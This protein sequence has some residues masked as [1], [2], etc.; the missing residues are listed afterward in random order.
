[1]NCNTGLIE[2]KSSL[3]RVIQTQKENTLLGM[4]PGSFLVFFNSEEMNTYQISSFLSQKFS[5]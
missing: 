5:E 2:L 4:S 1:M 3:S